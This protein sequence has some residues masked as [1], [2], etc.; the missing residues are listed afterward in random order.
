MILKDKLIHGKKSNA[1]VHS[2]LHYYPKW[3]GRGLFWQSSSLSPQ[4]WALN[5]IAAVVV[6]GSAR[7][8]WVL[9]L[10]ELSGTWA[11]KP[12]DNLRPIPEPT[13]RFTEV[14]RG[15]QQAGPQ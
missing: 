1:Y 11:V 8:E 14:Q 5:H 6:T 7:R 15:V 4:P 10:P 13:S 2:E 12:Q 3:L 9:T